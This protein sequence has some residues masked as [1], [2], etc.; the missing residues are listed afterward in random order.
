MFEFVRGHQCVEDLVVHA[1]GCGYEGYVENDLKI[2][3][4]LKVV[5]RFF[6]FYFLFR[7]IQDVELVFA[8]VEQGN[9]HNDVAE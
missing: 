3:A 8:H 9:Q 7:F 6:E 4:V 2:D 1:E 5:E